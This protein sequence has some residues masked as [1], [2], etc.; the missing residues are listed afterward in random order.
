[1][2]VIPAVGLFLDGIWK[3]DSPGICRDRR[4]RGCDSHTHVIPFGV[5]LSG[6]GAAV[7]LAVRLVKLAPLPAAHQPSC[8]FGS[9]KMGYIPPHALHNLTKYKYQGVDKWVYP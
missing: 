4:V 2:P 3:Y 5:F 9:Q 1:M 6:A 7:E 8:R